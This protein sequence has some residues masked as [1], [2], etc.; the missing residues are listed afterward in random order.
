MTPRTIFATVFSMKSRKKIQLTPALFAVSFLP[1]AA[2]AVFTSVSFITLT[3]RMIDENIISSA[4]GKLKLA[5]SQ[6][7]DCFDPA[8]SS[9]HSIAALT[10]SNQ[11]P[12]FISYLL[13]TI[14]SQYKS[15]SYYWTTLKPLPKGGTFLS[16]HNWSPPNAAWDQTAQPWFIGAKKMQGKLFCYAYLNAQTNDYCVSFTE[17]VYDSRHIMIGITGFD[18]GLDDLTK[19]T[20][21]ITVS[22]NGET[23][24]IDDKGRYVTHSDPKKIMA[25][26]YFDDSGERKE[27]VEESARIS[28]GTYIAGRHV[29]TMPWYVVAR[30]PV[31]D[32]TGAF[33][34]NILIVVVILAVLITFCLILNTVVVNNMQAKA[35]SLG[36]TLSIEMKKIR[37][38]IAGVTQSKDELGAVGSDM[39]VSVQDTSA[40]ITKMISSIDDVRQQIESQSSSVEETAGAVNQIAA[41]IEGLGRMITSQSESIS[42]ASSAVEQMIGGIQSV[43]GSVEK[44]A[45]SFGELQENMQTGIEKQQTVN[46][47][48]QQI[49]GQS[50]MLQEANTVIA[51]ISEQTN[52]LA[53]NAAIEAA[54]AGE[55][56]KGFAVVAD[57]IRKLSETSAEQSRTIGSQLGNI[58][59]SINEMVS[60]STDTSTTFT[61]VSKQVEDTDSLV[62]GIRETME[63]QLAGSK[64]IT[65]ALHSMNGSTAEVRDAAAEMG[66][67][68]QTILEEVRRLQEMTHSMNG[69]ITD[70]SEGTARIEETGSSLTAMTGRMHNAITKIGSQIDEFSA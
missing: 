40:A 24:I 42:Q 65:D 20:A 1:L 15:A 9:L 47:L 18:I 14:T 57:E 49:E 4:E 16:G 46:G 30:G 34:R 29:G 68:N 6:I 25:A 5:E 2:V 54:H 66:A 27:T 21:D 26:S 50:A 64:Q 7:T 38:I 37:G 44:M 61:Q 11:D 45:S 35:S 70:L 56:G 13:R 23:F 69:S 43:N 51:S 22:K 67:G 31:S 60:I 3:N 8:I 36:E 48:I 17:A 62:V 59:D 55:A 19:I 39:A 10:G 32:F 58:K 52:L 33:R 12:E 53:M 41:N 28:G 63:Q